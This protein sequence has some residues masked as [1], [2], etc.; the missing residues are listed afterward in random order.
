NIN[1]TLGNT[2]SYQSYNSGIFQTLDNGTNFVLDSNDYKNDVRY[3][4]NDAY[5]GVHYKFITG[6]FTFNPGVSFH[7]YNTFNDQLNSKVRDDF[8]RIL[9]DVFAQYQI[10]KSESLTYN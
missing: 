5:L 4:F 6:K 1:I 8:S 2:N 3:S 7:R 9:P 10:K